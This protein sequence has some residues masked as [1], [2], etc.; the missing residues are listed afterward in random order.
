M[1]VCVNICVLMKR[2][3]RERRERVRRERVCGVNWALKMDVGVW[4]WVLLAGITLA[5]VRGC[6]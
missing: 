6:Y 1:N 5:L 4:V 3:E 2:E